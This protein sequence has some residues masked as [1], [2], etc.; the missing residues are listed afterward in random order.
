MISKHADNTKI[1]GIVFSEDV[2]QESQQDLEL[3]GTWAEEWQMEFNSRLI[4][5]GKINH[6]MICTVKCRAMGSIAEQ[7]D[8]GV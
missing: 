8:L 7:R 5:F 1:G 3:P 6:G 2:Y 4:H